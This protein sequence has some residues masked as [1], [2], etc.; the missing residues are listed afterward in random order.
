MT[1]NYLFSDLIF[2]FSV[3]DCEGFFSNFFSPRGDLGSFGVHGEVR[4]ILWACIARTKHHCLFLLTGFD[5]GSYWLK[6]LMNP[7]WVSGSV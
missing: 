4:F 2:F 5:L 1:F 6:N 3:Q 7:A